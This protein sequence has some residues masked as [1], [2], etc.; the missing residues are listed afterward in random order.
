MMRE[1]LE[2]RKETGGCLVF[3]ST[4]NLSFYCSASIVS[5]VCRDCDYVAVAFVFL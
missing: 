5:I 4:G 3:M 1:R 2:M